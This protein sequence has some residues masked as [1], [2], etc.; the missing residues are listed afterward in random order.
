MQVYFQA[1]NR[2]SAETIYE[3]VFLTFYNVLYTSWPILIL[4][5][6]E[7]PH[8]ETKLMR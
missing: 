5:L 8:T 4:S 2:F 3:S 7:K 6:T 1:N